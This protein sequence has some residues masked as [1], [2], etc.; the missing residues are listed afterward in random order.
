MGG[1]VG[2]TDSLRP[3]Q[4][5]CTRPPLAPET[6]WWH[7]RFNWRHGQV[8]EHQSLVCQQDSASGLSV[9]HGRWSHPGRE[10][11]GAPDDEGSYGTVRHGLMATPDAWVFAVEYKIGEYKKDY[12]LWRSVSVAGAWTITRYPA[13]PWLVVF[14]WVVWC[15]SNPAGQ[16][17]LICTCEACEPTRR[18]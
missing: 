18:P 2:V 7:S 13:T 8:R 9:T 1:K 5:A 6:I 15:K 16:N 4:I 3:G 11:P 14:L 10:V 12:F 17:W